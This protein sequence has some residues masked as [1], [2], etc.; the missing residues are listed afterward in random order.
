MFLDT[1]RKLREPLE[2][3]SKHTIPVL[4]L[5]T[6]YTHYAICQE[7]RIDLERLVEEVI[8][9]IL[10]QQVLMEYKCLNIIYKH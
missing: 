7:R 3:L 2:A 4:S 1:K 9:L 6:T 5:H 10:A 8:V